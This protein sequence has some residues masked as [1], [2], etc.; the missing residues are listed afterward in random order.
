CVAEIGFTQH[1]VDV[2]VSNEQAALVHD[3]GHA[4]LA[5]LNLGDQVNNEFQVDFCDRDASGATRPRYRHGQIGLRFPA[6]VHGTEIAFFAFGIDERR[7]FAQIRAAAHGVHGKA[8]YLEL[9]S[10][11]GVEIADLGNRRGLTQEPEKIE[12]SLFKATAGRQKSRCPADLPLDLLHKLL[13]DGG[14]PDRLLA[15]HRAERLPAFAVGIVELDQRI[16]EQ[17]AAHQRDQENSVL[18]EQPTG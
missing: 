16:D 4:G 11:F 12:P 5:D 8:R 1:Q 2:R 6:E 9:L 14:G 13:D 7:L 3:V 15:L 18:P 17:G 10:P